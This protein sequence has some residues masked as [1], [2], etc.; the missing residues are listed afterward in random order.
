VTT[1]KVPR[2]EWRRAPDFA[3]VAEA[4]GVPTTSILAVTTQEGLWLVYYNQEGDPEDLLS[5]TLLRRGQDGILFMAISPSVHP[6]LWDRITRGIED[7]LR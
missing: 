2:V 3:E 7:K 6:G 4:L 5:S 1:D